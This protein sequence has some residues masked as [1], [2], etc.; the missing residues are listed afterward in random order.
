MH[1]DYARP[2]PDGDWAT[3]K[4][5]VEYVAR[6]V[7][8]KKHSDDDFEYLCNRL[9]T[10]ETQAHADRRRAAGLEAA[11]R[12]LLS[13]GQVAE[14]TWNEEMRSGEKFL[15][16]MGCAI[17]SLGERNAG[18]RAALAAYGQNKPYGSERGG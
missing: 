11:L 4:D 2:T 9:D 14:G 8:D 5:H 6:V 18:A 17:G 12:E 1:S 13:A 7:A 15:N 16:L 10:L 3:Y